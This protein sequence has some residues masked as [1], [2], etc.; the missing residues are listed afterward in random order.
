MIPAKTRIGPAFR[1]TDFF[2]SSAAFPELQFFPA[3]PAYSASF[4]PPQQIFPTLKRHRHALRTHAPH[5][6]PDIKGGNYIPFYT[7]SSWRMCL[8]RRRSYRSRQSRVYKFD[9]P[10][11]PRQGGG[12]GRNSQGSTVL[13]Y[14][15]CKCVYNRLKG[16]AEDFS[17]LF[18]DSK[19]LLTFAP[20]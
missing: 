1:G 14:R 20:R 10:P 13:D 12:F 9:P 19:I 4:G 11:S 17:D 2:V 5:A 8:H 15:W 18:A 16:K 7:E 3:F 6:L